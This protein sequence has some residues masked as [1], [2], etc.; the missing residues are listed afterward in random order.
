[1]K[2]VYLI[3]GWGGSS[4]GGW[5]D[6]VRREA[7]G[8]AEI[9]AFD[10]PNPDYP[11]IEKWVKFIWENVKGIDEETYFIGHSIGCQAILRFLERL[12]EGMKI[13]G[14]VF[15]AGW[16]N[17]KPESLA[18]EEEKQIAKPWLETPVDFEKI[19]SH[20]KNFLAVFSDNDPFVPLTEEKLFE[21]ELNAKTIVRH[22][23]GHF[24]KRQ[25]M[26]EVIK[27]LLE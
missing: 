27:F 1:M 3:H 12:P 17:L 22:N 13:S 19:K 11:E 10:M 21:K 14:C 25:E 2:K 26:P 8:K 7:A 24:E 23:E 16:L 20:C 9:R 18:N 4:S 5:F 15:V 6:W